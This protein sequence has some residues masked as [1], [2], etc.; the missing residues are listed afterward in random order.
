[1]S[2]PASMLRREKAAEKAKRKRV[3]VVK[4][5]VDNGDIVFLEGPY[6]GKYASQLFQ[7]GPAE[8]DYVVN[9]LWFTNDARVME[10]LKRFVCT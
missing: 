7:M 4:Y 2:G 9:N 1:M 3:Q 10:I 5:Q 8:R 6:G